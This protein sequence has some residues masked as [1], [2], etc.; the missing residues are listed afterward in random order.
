MKKIIMRIIDLNIL[1]LTF[2]FILSSF[3]KLISYTMI[4]EYIYINSEALLIIWILGILISLTATPH[5]YQGI[6]RLRK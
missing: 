1:I 2:F 4:D 3:F 5:L 6:L